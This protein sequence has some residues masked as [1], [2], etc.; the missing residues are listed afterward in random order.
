LS[1]I[2]FNLTTLGISIESEPTVPRVISDELY[3]T[4]G[5]F[6]YLCGGEG[7]ANFDGAAVRVVGGDH[8]VP[9]LM[10]LRRAFL[11]AYAD[12]ISYVDPAST[13]DRFKS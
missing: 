4:M 5:E 7:D 13:T 2:L 10:Q 11:H 12:Q 3:K 1:S 8:A 6:V 9:G